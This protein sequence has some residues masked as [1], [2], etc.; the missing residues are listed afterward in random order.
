MEDLRKTVDLLMKSGG[1]MAIVL[2]T[3]QNERATIIVALSP[4][5]VKRGLHAGNISKEVAKIIGGGG[6]GRPDMAQAGGQLVDKLDEAL[7][8]TAELLSKKIS[9][10][11]T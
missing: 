2:G 3:T 7:N 5:I 6:G 8:S 1:E 9:Q 10:S 11:N 4:T